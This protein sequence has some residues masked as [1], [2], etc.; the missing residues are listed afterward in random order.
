M[1]RTGAILHDAVLKGNGYSGHGPGKNNPAM[2]SESDVGPIPSGRY[3]IAELIDRDPVCGEY[4]LVLMPAPAN[5]MF[6]RSGFRWHGDSIESPGQASHGCIVSS[7]ALRVEVWESSDHD[8]QIIREPDLP[9][10]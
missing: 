10:S 9:K 4:V 5:Q 3:S 6:G 1:Q 2:E 7:R 8:L